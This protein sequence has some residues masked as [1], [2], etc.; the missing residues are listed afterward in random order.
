MLLI[1]IYEKQQN[2][3]LTGYI[4][5]LNRH[6]DVYEN[7]VKN[8]ETRTCVCNH[9]RPRSQCVRWFDDYHIARSR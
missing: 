1:S 7:N 4:F 8:I 3:N 6:G 9:I 5:M 2:G